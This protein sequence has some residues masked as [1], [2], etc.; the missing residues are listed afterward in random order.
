[1][2]QIVSAFIIVHWTEIRLTTFYG[3]FGI[4]DIEVGFSYALSI[5]T[6]VALTN[7]FNLIDGI[8]GLAATIGILC[9]AIFG[10]W[11]FLMGSDQFAILAFSLLGSLFGFLYYNWSPAKIFMGDTGSLI[12][13]FVIS[14][15]AV[16]FIE[17]NRIMDKNA[18]F[19]I[20]SVPVVTIAILI[21]PIFDT[22]R[23][24]LIRIMKRK[25][26]FI[27]D[28]SHV[29]HV[30]LSIGLSHQKCVLIILIFNILLI[31]LNFFLKGHISGE[32]LLVI[33]LLLPTFSMFL[34]TSYKKNSFKSF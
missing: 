8:D 31:S 28:R 32:V 34:I 15:L 6:I 22:L 17:M 9:S 21:V 27:A 20:H 5:F 24:F 12:V 13:G 16:K 10:Y 14:I 3:L 23:V 4:W 33:N 1:M 2:V 30:L 18:Q 25:S 11:F 26:P 7:A 29:H 19:K